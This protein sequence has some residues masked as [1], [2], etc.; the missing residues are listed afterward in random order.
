MK[1]TK[2]AQPNHRSKGLESKSRTSL[3]SSKPLTQLPKSSDRLDVRQKSTDIPK[4]TEMQ[5]S[6]GMKKTH[7][8]KRAQTESSRKSLISKSRAQFLVYKK[9]Y[10]RDGPQKSIVSPN[11]PQLSQGMKRNR[12]NSSSK[13][14]VENLPKKCM[15]EKLHQV[16]CCWS[17]FSCVTI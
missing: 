4:Q 10:K 5:S 7:T 3:I 11:K 13:G 9:S 2:E 12:S 6:Q 16:C 17:C 8:S 1:F 15:M 14:A